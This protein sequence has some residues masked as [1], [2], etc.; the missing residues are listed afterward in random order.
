MR[1]RW[2]CLKRN[3]HFDTVKVK[4][5]GL[6]LHILGADGLH[7]VILRWSTAIQSRWHGSLANS[8]CEYKRVLWPKWTHTSNHGTLRQNHWFSSELH[9]AWSLFI[10]ALNTIIMGFHHSRGLGKIFRI[11]RCWP[12]IQHWQICRDCCN[13]SFAGLRLNVRCWEQY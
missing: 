2:G 1:P 8:D 13:K 3:T 6:S 4:I 10:P 7:I 11:Y 12:C 9:S 5:S